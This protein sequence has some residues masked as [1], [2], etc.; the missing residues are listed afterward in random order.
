MKDANDRLDVIEFGRRLLETRDLDPLYFILLHSGMS[1]FQLSRWLV[2]YWCYYHAG[3]C[4]W[5]TDRGPKNFWPTMLKIA[6][7]GSQYPRGTE[8]RHFRGKL[9]VQSISRLQSSFA[10]PDHLIDW[11]IEGGPSARGICKRV[12]CL[13]GFGD[14]VKWKVP[15]MLDRLGLAKVEFYDSDVDLMFT[16]SKQGAIE[17]YRKHSLNGPDQLISAHQ[18]L[19]RELRN[20]LAPPL[21]DRPINVQET[22]TIFCKW[23]SHLTGHYPIGKDTHEIG[24]GLR[25]YGS[26]RTSQSLLKALL[27]HVLGA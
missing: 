15:D 4:C 7:G 23:K 10:R 5:V 13:Y 22:E 14:W 8:R 20:R 11:L 24:L 27:E 17:T 2:C 1:R 25:R 9:A 6:L 19:L 12:T 21:Y 18:Y 26:C 3:L 16:S